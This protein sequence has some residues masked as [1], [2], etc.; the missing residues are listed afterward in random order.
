MTAET[1]I[2][3]T[4][5]ATSVYGLATFGLVIQIWWDRRQRER[6]FREEAENRKLN[7]LRGAFYEAWGYWEG[8][9]HT[10]NKS[11]AAQAGKIFEATVRLECQLRLNGYKTEANNLGFAVR[12]S[13]TQVGEQ[14]SKVGVALGLFPPEYRQA[15]AV[16]LQSTVRP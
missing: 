1:A 3:I 8:L 2:V 14:L 4:A 6:H 15:T 12:A 7:E 13:L 10:P 11:D 16:G 9:G 5:I